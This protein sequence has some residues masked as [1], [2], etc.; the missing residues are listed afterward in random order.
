MGRTYDAVLRAEEQRK[1]L[2]HAAAL[3]DASGESD[4]PPGERGLSRW[5]RWVSNG[6]VGAPSKAAQTELVEQIASLEVTVGALDDQLSREL[7]EIERRLV[8]QAG[9]DL[10]KLE[11]RLSRLVSTAA[12]ATN[13]QLDQLTRRI[14]LLLSLILA[15]L[16]AIL[17]RI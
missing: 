2:P 10:K 14:S 9:E 7:P 11:D 8:G 16:L 5:K 4:P 12:D 13:R 1:R 17:L 3:E 15:A 6:E